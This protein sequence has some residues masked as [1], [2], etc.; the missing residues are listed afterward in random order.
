[1]DTLQISLDENVYQLQQIIDDLN[2]K[3]ASISVLGRGL[4]E[5]ER[6]VLP[7]LHDALTQLQSQLMGLLLEEKMRVGVTLLRSDQAKLTVSDR[8]NL[9]RSVTHNFIANVLPIVF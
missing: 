9:F 4:T 8:I 6:E 3:R 5:E 1:M 2:S 7:L